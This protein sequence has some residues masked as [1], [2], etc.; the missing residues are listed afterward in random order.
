MNIVYHRLIKQI[1]ERNGYGS[2]CDLNSFVDEKGREWL[3]CSCEDFPETSAE[4]MFM[5][6]ADDEAMILLTAFASGVDYCTYEVER[7]LSRLLAEKGRLVSEVLDPIIATT[8]WSAYMAPQ[9]LLSYLAAKPDG[10]M[11]ILKLLDVVPNDARDG[12]F[13]ACWFSNSKIVHDKLI[14]KFE[15]WM[16]DPSWGGG[17]VECAWLREF[18]GKWSSLPDIDR[19][20]FERFRSLSSRIVSEKCFC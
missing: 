15:S 3:S 7:H 16:V 5:D 2:K 18:V 11:W 14:S 13:T 10:E 1:A 17:D 6:V 4:W 12:L 9:M 20:K 8:D 19:D